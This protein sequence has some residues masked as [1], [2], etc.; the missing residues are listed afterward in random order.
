MPADPQSS[1]SSQDTSVSTHFII[2]KPD[3]ARLETSEDLC[4]S[5]VVKG[6]PEKRQTIFISDLSSFEPPCTSRAQNSISGYQVTR[7][8]QQRRAEGNDK[9]SKTALNTRMESLSFR[10][11]DFRNHSIIH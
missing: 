5:G 6:D 2:Q 4:F 7:R 1:W 10:S 8:N 11:D 3:E 9:V